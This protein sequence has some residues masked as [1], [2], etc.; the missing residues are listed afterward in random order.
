MFHFVSSRT[1]LTVPQD[2]VNHLKEYFGG[3]FNLVG[4]YK[5][6]E[7]GDDEFVKCYIKYR[8]FTC[9]WHPNNNGK[10]IEVYDNNGHYLG[11]ITR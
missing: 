10:S 7:V 3:Y 4:R 1:G 2:V 8:G 9:Q 11:E 5:M 6:T